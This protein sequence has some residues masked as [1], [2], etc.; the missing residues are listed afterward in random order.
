MFPRVPLFGLPAV[1]SE[2]DFGLVLGREFTVDQ[3]G[4]HHDIEVESAGLFDG[5]DIDPVAVF[6]AYIEPNLTDRRFQ[7]IE[8]R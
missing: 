8:I 3:S 2:K 6:L 4:D 1:F 5:R 7:L